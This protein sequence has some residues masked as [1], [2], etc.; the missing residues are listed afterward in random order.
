V[1]HSDEAKIRSCAGHRRKFIVIQRRRIA[2]RDVF[3][4]LG[5]AAMGFGAIGDRVLR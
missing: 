3:E 2:Q 1:L 5:H 4:S